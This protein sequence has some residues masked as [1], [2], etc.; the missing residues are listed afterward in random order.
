[1]SVRKTIF[2]V[3]LSVGVAAG[4]VIL[5]LA[6]T[7]VLLTY[8]NQ[9]TRWAEG[10]YDLPAQSVPRLTADA[11][12]EAAILETGGT[13]S[14][15]LFENDPEAPVAAITGRNGKL[16]LDLYTG[17]ALGT[18]DTATAR[19][20]A[21]VEHLHR[22]F[23]LEGTGRA[24]GKAI[25]G[26]ANL[27]FLFLLVSGVYLWWPKAWKW[28]IV[29]M[30]LWFRPGL[31]NAKARDYNWHHVF[32][33]W[34]LIPLFCIVISGVVISYPWA[35]DLVYRLYGEEPAAGGRP[36]GAGG[37]TAL[38][39]R[40]GVGLQAILDQARASD[41][42]WAR[43]TLAFPQGAGKPTVNAT[44]DT[45]TGRQP[46]RQVTRTYAL[47]DGALVATK[48]TGQQT[49]GRRA[50]IFL[51]FLHTGE[52][53]GLLG[54]TLAG[55]ASAVTLIMVYTGLALSYRRLIRPLLLR[56]RHS[57]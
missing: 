6:A 42:D 51:R 22:W 34:A 25:T 5:M 28:R 17:D 43:I 4:L 8:E 49:P 19:F 15:L 16:F 33:F 12:A 37:Q 41:P 30:N 52:V 47:S 54:Q 45:G 14:A 36:G 57:A 53:F 55:L 48:G 32:G 10:G 46:A 38:P 31:P 39:A 44:V 20:F 3:H 24:T 27:G 29:R 56:R 7:G 26:V 50:R 35:G 9:I 2:W 13:A 1:M 21:G 18:N 23:A 40:M 11:L